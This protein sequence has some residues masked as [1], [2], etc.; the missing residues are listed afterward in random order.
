MAS[1]SYLSRVIPFKRHA[2]VSAKMI[3]QIRCY[4]AAQAYRSHRDNHTEADAE[5]FVAIAVGSIEGHARYLAE[6]G[7]LDHASNFVVRL[8][9]LHVGR[10]PEKIALRVESNANRILWT[11]HVLSGKALALVAAEAL[12]RSASFFMRC[13]GASDRARE[14]IRETL[15][16][17]GETAR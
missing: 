4:A 12:L 7:K 2:G 11:A 15:G 5:G 13:G 6:Q 17:P 1:I 16:E 8:S 10:H 9:Q 14:V 3:G